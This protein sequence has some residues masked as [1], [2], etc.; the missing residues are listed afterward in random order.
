MNYVK[1]VSQIAKWGQRVQHRFITMQ[2]KQYLSP[3]SFRTGLASAELVSVDPWSGVQKFSKILAATSKLYAPEGLCEGSSILSTR[4]TQGATT[5]NS[6]AR[7][8][9]HKGFVQPDQHIAKDTEANV[10]V[11]KVSC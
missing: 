5:Q 11:F 2:I 7:A 3:I 4:K 1:M 6:L 8:I 10:K 9:W